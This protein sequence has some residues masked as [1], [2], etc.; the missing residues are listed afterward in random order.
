MGPIRDTTE[1]VLVVPGNSFAAE[2][3]PPSTGI[4]RQFGSHGL[5]KVLPLATHPQYL[6]TIGTKLRMDQASEHATRKR[7]DLAR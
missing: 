6:I 4:P 2:V 1:V 7:C 5:L 3:K